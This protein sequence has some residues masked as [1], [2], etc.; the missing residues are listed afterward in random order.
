MKCTSEVFAKIPLLRTSFPYGVVDSNQVCIGIFNFRA[1]AKN[2]VKEDPD[3]R[4]L[5][6]ASGCLFECH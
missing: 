6:D 3:N 1:D 5:F 2:F 4:S